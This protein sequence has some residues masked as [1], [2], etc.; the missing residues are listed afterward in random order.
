MKPVLLLHNHTEQ[1]VAQFARQPVHAVMLVGSSGVGKTY[2]A[3]YMLT[4]LLGLAPGGLAA[5]PYYS[6][7]QPDKGSI[8]IDAVR[9]L[10]RFLQLKTIGQR[11]LRRAVIVEHADNMTTEAQNAFLKL[12]EEPPA[13]TILVVTVDNQRALLPTILSRAQ[14]IPVY[15]PDEQAIKAHFAEQGKEQAAII[16]AY[17]LSGGLP[18]LMSALLAEDDSHPLLRGVIAAKEVLQKQTFERLAMVETFSKQKEEAVYMLQ[19]LQ[20]IARTGLAQGAAKADPAKVKQWHHILKVTTAALDALD[21]SA[22]TKL[23]LT[24]L[25]LQL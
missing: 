10:Q 11:P 5:H 6:L 1:R 7:V 24:N 4:G 15:A 22:N 13:D 9:D 8:S 12:L 14:S 17:F 19:A 18:G 21:Q 2:L 16:Q 23:T 25:M 20:H 3:E